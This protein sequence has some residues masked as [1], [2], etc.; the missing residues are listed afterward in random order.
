LL[1]TKA[2][3]FSRADRLGDPFEGSI[4]KRMA[5]EP[6]RFLPPDAATPIKAS[7]SVLRRV[8]TKNTIVN[9][10]HRSEY[11]SAAMWK[12]YGVDDRGVAIRSTRARLIKSLPPRDD[13]VV[14]L[15]VKRKPDGCHEALQ[16]YVG[17]VTY[18]DYESGIFRDNN[19][20]LPFLHKRR[21]FEHER[22]L[23]AI[24]QTIPGKFGVSVL[25]EEVS[26]FDRGGDFVPIDLAALV[27]SLYVAPTAPLWFVELVQSVVDQYGFSF[28]VR[29][30][31][32]DGDPIF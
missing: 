16:I 8:L 10:W 19:T 18:I 7:M 14:A 29:R 25:T 5:D 21:S 17:E 23:R 26:C 3:F 28:P 11:E 24:A 13:E 4:P 6:A 12:L 30:S 32:L 20:G 31:A 2:L 22:E 15:R 1:S 9:C 27:E